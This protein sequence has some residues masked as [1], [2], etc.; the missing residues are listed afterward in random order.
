MAADIRGGAPIGCDTVPSAACDSDGGWHKSRDGARPARTR[1]SA[2]R[3]RRDY[4]SEWSAAQRGAGVSPGMPVL[5][6]ACQEERRHGRRR[7]NLKGRS[8]DRARLRA[9]G[10]LI[11]RRRLKTCPT[12]RRGAR[13]IMTD[14]GTRTQAFGDHRHPPGSGISLTLKEGGR[15]DN[16]MSVALE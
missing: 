4:S 13:K 2:S 12:I 7:G 6:P 10:G 3:I 14:S 16:T 1:G 9:A 15:I 5:L 8:T 11:I